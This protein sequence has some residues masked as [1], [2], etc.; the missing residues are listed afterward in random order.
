[1]IKLNTIYNEDCFKTLN[2]MI[3]DGFKTDIVLTSP[4]YNNSRSDVEDRSTDT[5]SN[6]YDIYTDSKTESEYC[7]WTVELFNLFD[8]VLKENGVILYNVSYGNEAPNTLWLMLADVINKTPFM[9]ADVINWKKN[10]ALPQN[11]SPNKLTRICEFVFV[12]CRKSEYMTYTANKPV[13]S[14]RSTG[15]KMYGVVYNYISAPNNDGS[16]ALN[17]ATYSSDLCNKLLS[18]YAKPNSIV[19]DPFMG[20]G[21]TAVACKQM[22]HYYVGSELSPAQ[23][24]YALERLGETTKIEKKKAVVEELF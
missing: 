2:N 3:D 8:K 20:T 16:C 15:Q 21:T 14:V 5:Y 1:M 12:L 13:T 7:D 17:K 4:P 10:S 11:I 23:C 6:R 22:G 9:I 24:E 19:Y 18:I